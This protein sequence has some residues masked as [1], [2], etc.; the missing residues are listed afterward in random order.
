MSFF[1]LLKYYLKQLEISLRLSKTGNGISNV[2]ISLHCV[3]KRNSYGLN[4]G[5]AQGYFSTILK[6]LQPPFH[7][8]DHHVP[9]PR[10]HVSKKILLRS[11]PL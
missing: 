8:L 7:N 2:I 10:Q 1:I 9:K 5:F 11:N 3:H 4:L 6:N